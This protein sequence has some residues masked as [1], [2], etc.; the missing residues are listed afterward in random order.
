MRPR[1][2]SACGRRGSKPTFCHAMAGLRSFCEWHLPTTQRSRRD[3]L[4][5]GTDS[6]RNANH[7]HKTLFRLASGRQEWEGIRVETGTVDDSESERDCA[8][9]VPQSSPK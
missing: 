3:E 2:T 6:T 1:I 5:S 8:N 4:C 7:S 9:S